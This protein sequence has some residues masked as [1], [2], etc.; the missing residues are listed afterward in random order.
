MWCVT[1]LHYTSAP[2]LGLARGSL[3]EERGLFLLLL[4]CHH[5]Q[6]T[7][8]SRLRLYVSSLT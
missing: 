4:C 5:L 7:L 3:W 1:F 2:L 8:L 6:L